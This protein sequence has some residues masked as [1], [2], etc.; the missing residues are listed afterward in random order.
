MKNL[1]DSLNT[2]FSDN[3]TIT[4]EMFYNISFGHH[5]ISLQGK[6]SVA[7]IAAFKGYNFSR[8]KSEVTDS[9]FVEITFVYLYANVTVTL[10]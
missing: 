2:L 9:G 1:L 8:L 10:T 3:A 7:T 4:P 6:F 5:S